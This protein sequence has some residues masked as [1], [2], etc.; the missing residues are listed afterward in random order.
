MLEDFRTAPISDREKA[1]FAFIEKMNRASTS[2]QKADVDALVE[3]GWTEEAV[4]DAITVC[5]LFNF[6]NKWIDATGVSDMPAEAYS[7]SGERLATMGYL[8]HQAAR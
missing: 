2:L 8:P 6:F 7:A 3:T 1:L 4:Y 5:A